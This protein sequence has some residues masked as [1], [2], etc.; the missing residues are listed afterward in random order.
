MILWN[1]GG[2]WFGRLEF[3]GVISH[4]GREFEK[5]VIVCVLVLWCLGCDVLRDVRGVRRHGMDLVM[6]FG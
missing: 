6:E 1:M 5:G 2:V 3:R 4:G